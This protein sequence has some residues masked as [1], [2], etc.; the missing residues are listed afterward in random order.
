M[1]L[2]SIMCQGICKEIMESTFILADLTKPN[3][4]V[5]YELGL[6][7]G[8]NKNIIF[9][10]NSLST[11]EYLNIFKSAWGESN[12]YIE[13]EDVY[14]IEKRLKKLN[15]KKNL[16]LDEI[17]NNKSNSKKILIL[18]NCQSSINGLYKHVLDEIKPEFKFDIDAR[19]PLTTQ[20]K[21]SFA[22]EDW[23]KLETQ[24]HI[25]SLN[26]ELKTLIEKISEAKICMIDTTAYKQVTQS[27]INP[28]MYFCLGIAHSLEKEVI[29][30]TNAIQPEITPF[31]VKGLWHI[32]FSD[33]NSLKSGLKQIIPKIVIDIH[34]EIVNEPYSK[35]WD[36]FLLNQDR[37]SI[38]YCGRPN[39]E[40][41]R[42]NRGKRINI[43]S[44]DSKTVS[45]ASFYLAQ[46][47]TTTE[48]KP[49]PPQAKYA[50]QPNRRNEKQELIKKIK[51]SLIKKYPNCIVIG[52]PDV[53]DYAEVLLAELYNIEPYDKKTDLSSNRTERF[54]FHKNKLIGN[55]QSSFYR[56]STKKEDNRVDF[57]GLIS[58]Y[59]VD[60]TTYGVLTIA[61]N[62]FN[63]AGK[64]MVL[65]G[66]TGLATFGLLQLVTDVTIEDSDSRVEF[67]KELK[68]QIHK[69][70]DKTSKKPFSVFVQF[71]YEK[72]GK[73]IVG[74]DRRI[75][76][77]SVIST[78]PK[79]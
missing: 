35:I 15:L 27:E 55:V 8:L 12:A 69:K 68:E 6:A 14:S 13:F 11:N 4:N 24:T 78:H 41:E 17:N 72:Q 77:V 66:Y 37:L 34:K 22:E 46:K 23:K 36:A 49:A 43:D 39:T 7:Y 54:V 16:V 74:D 40:E 45:E 50:F 1:R 44:W 58:G 29:P 51:N 31:D 62:P 53:S 56:K 9:L 63:E 19:F 57:F 47:Y 48:I 5:Y 65:S 28:I 20:E 60:N 25:I 42:K 18:E 30:I 61:K 73:A 32:F 70:Y 26:T 75:T 10:V 59:C 67:N 79:K 21:S 76:S 2:G 38:I 3:P 71:E 64:I 33:E 52:S